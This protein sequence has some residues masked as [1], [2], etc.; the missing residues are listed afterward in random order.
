LFVL[1]L[2]DGHVNLAG[3]DF[4]LTPEMVSQATG[5]PNVGEEWNKRKLLDRFQY[6]PYIKPEYMRYMTGVFPF[7]F[8]KDEYVPLMRLIMRYFTCEG[9]FSRL[10]L[11]HIRLLMHFTRVRMMNIPFFMCRN[12]EKM[13]PLVQRKSPAQQHRSIYHYALIKIVVMHQ[14]AQQ[15]IPWE[16]FI[17]RD[18]FTAPPP[19]PEVVHEE[20]GPSQQHDI[21]EVRHVSSPLLVTYQRGHRAL[22]ASARRVFSPHQV[23]GVSPSSSAPRVLSPHQVEGA[24]F[25]TAAQVSERGK[26]PM[27]E[28][29]LSGDPDIDI[30]DLDTCSPSSELREII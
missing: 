13:V 7:R 27:I 30:I 20:G 26:Q 12:I 11:Y 23:E 4:T 1:H 19:P 25:P 6:E 10:F 29:G 16:D 22:F 15:G 21:P 28:E 17:S 2:H 5:I 14:L 9:R 18:F 24:S 3:V 8:L